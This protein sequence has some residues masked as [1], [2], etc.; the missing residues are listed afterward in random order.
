[1]TAVLA[2]VALPAA[3]LTIW[4][5]L[6]SPL[7]LRLV[8][9]PRRDRWHERQTPLL[10]GVGLFA[11]LLAGVG[12][13]LAAG[14]L[15]PS[16]ELFGI[17]GGCAIVF[18]AGLLDDLRALP[19]AAKLASQV[20]AGALVVATGLQVQIVGNDVLATAIALLWLV[21]MTNAFNLLDNMDGLAA[22]LA[23]IACAF[24]AI[25]AVTVNSNH[26][27]LVISLARAFACAGFLSFNVR[28]HVPARA[29]LGDWG[30]QVIGFSLG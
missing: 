13:A 27:V 20:G 5:L 10:G 21:G 9:E 1:M 24:F 6:R 23:G 30:S 14:A 12:A 19:P 16:E 2:T 4:A 17:L 11:G 7:G 15:H 3:A 29:F 18:T 25:A 22:S 28:F 26:L 8:A